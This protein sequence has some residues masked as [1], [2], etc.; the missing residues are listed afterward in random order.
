MKIRILTITFILIMTFSLTVRADV[1]AD[2]PGNPAIIT[3]VPVLLPQEVPAGPVLSTGEAETETAAAPG[4]GSGI[5]RMTLGFSL[6]CPA[7][8]QNNM[9]LAQGSVQLSDGSWQDLGY[10]ACIRSPYFRLLR[11]AVDSQGISWYIVRVNGNR[12]GNA[13]TTDGTRVTELWLLKSDCTMQNYIDLP[14]GNSTRQ[15][16]VAAA[17][18]LLGCRYAYAGS[19]PDAFDCSG[20]V[21]YVCEKAGVSIPRTSSEVC[22]MSGQVSQANLRPGDIC[23]RNGHVGIYVG[24]DVF[25]HASESSTGV[26]AEYLSV[27]NSANPFTNYINVAGD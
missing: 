22:A 15:K 25:V 23:A 18:E 14:A 4:P 6:I 17:L 9:K 5:T 3:D 11:E 24:N 8:S 10:D 26:I 7:H 19:G 12:V 20:L 2:R 27:Y 13:H 21:K 16:I 1:L